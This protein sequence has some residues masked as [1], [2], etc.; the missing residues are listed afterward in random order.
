MTL[1]IANINFDCDD[2]ARVAAFWA[3]ALNLAVDDGGSEYFCS[4]TTTSPEGSPNLLFLK[5]PEPRT[6]KNR[7]HVDLVA[8]DREKEIARLVELG[9]TRGTDHDE[10]GHAWTVMADPEAN[11]FCIAQQP[12]S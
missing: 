5:V 2:P 9:A 8:D 1:Y 12:A 11:D 10:Y 3:E 6:V 7:V 4:I